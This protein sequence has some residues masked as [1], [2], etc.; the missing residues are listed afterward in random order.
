ML[1]A[2]R[3]VEDLLQDQTTQPRAV[4][5]VVKGRFQI[6]RELARRSLC[7]SKVKKSSSVLFRTT[8]AST[9]RKRVAS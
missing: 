7:A 4:A 5:F 9:L 2:Y 6:W 3:A 1:T 8:L